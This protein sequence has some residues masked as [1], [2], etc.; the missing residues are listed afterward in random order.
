MTLAIYCAGGLGREIIALARAVSRWQAI[1]FVDDIT[2]EK[3]IEGAAVYRFDEVCTFTDIEYEFV[4][5]S[6]EPSVRAALYKKVKAAGF[7]MATI[8]GR[9]VYVLT[10]SSI[11]EGCILYDCGVSTGVTLG[12]NTLVSTKVVIGHNVTIGESCVISAFSFLGGGTSIGSRTYI[13]AGAKLKDHVQV[14]VDVIIGLGAVIFRSVTDG[15][16]MIGNPAKKIGENIEKKVFS[17][18]KD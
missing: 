11:G 7:K 15:A 9:G 10:G 18:F 2:K 3:W 1:I 14:G 4:I 5:A 6:G 17:L 12:N 13:G 16:I 8:Y